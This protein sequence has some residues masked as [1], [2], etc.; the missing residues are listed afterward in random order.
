MQ[1]HGGIFT[2]GFEG[3]GLP[4]EVRD[5]TETQGRKTRTRSLLQVT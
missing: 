3:Q 1:Q 5:N 4:G 2:L